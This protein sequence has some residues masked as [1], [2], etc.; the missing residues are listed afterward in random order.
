MLHHSCNEKLDILASVFTLFSPYK[1]CSQEFITFYLREILKVP[2]NYMTE[3]ADGNFINV[4][5]H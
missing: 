2:L 3:I 4:N 5:Y 1:K